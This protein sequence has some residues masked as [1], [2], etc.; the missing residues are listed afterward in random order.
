MRICHITIN[1]IDFERR[2]YNQIETA[3]KCGHKVLVIS[4]GKPGEK[5]RERKKVY[6]LWRITT[7]YHKGGP[8]KF[9]SFNIKLFFYLL[10]TPI[11]I[12][13]CHDLW[14]LPAAAFAAL[15]KNS[16]LV[17]DAH[18]YYHGLEIF[19]NRPIRKQIWMLCEWLAIPIVDALITVSGPL[20]DLYKKRY[21]QLK[22]AEVIR[23]VPKYEV[24]QIDESIQRIK[25]DDKKVVIFHG[26]FK[27]GRGL[28]NLVKAAA[29]FVDTRML[30]V[31]GGELEPILSAIVQ[32]LDLSEVVE[33]SDYI[34]NDLLISHASQAD[35]GI[36]LFE[37]TSINY[38]YALPNKF[39][40][41]MMAGLPILASNI[42]TFTYYIE[43]YNIGKTVDPT[44]PV[45]IA[46][47]IKEMLQDTDSMREWKTNCLT[48]A[49]E[50]NW[51]NES[52]KLAK[53]YGGCVL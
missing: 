48:A 40:E 39:F 34:P 23:N 1:K 41:Y 43:K 35:I 22:K 32:K 13:H 7:R 52:K 15:L 33:F 50:L 11:N 20:A 42:D 19:K 47:T 12:I 17:Y 25:Q 21:P 10:F 18:E 46:K 4:I 6:M 31:G 36:V 27:P 14:P 9:I 8:I 45:L 16:S 2:I 28:E 51:E 44:N 38:S 3:Q 24:P 37:P 30:L 29:G 49:K 26:H 53:I 5:R